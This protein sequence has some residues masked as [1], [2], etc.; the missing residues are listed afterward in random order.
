MNVNLSRS[1]YQPRAKAVRRVLSEPKDVVGRDG[2]TG[3]SSRCLEVYFQK[4]S[5]TK[6]D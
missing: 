6:S 5:E 1:P 2:A 3:G 4:G